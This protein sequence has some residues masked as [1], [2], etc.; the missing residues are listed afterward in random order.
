MRITN[1]HGLPETI[2][3]AV[4]KQRPPKPG[5]LHVSQ[6]I[7]PPLQVALQRTYF[8]DIEEDASDR[9]WILFGSL[10]HGVLADNA[11]PGIMVEETFQMYAGWIVTGTV[12]YYRDRVLADYKTTSVWSIIKGIKP[13]WINQINLYATLLE[14]N[15]WPV[16]RAE[17]VVILRD[18]SRSKAKQGGNYPQSNV[19]VLPMPVWDDETRLDYLLERVA[20]HRAAAAQHD[21]ANIIVCTPE[22][23]WQ[24]PTAYAV[25]K[26]GRKR[27]VKVFKGENAAVDAE[28]YCIRPPDR[29]Y[30][31]VQER[32]SIP[33][34]CQHYCNVNKWCPW[35]AENKPEEEA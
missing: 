9:I 22:E 10:L 6:L 4:S 8:D 3:R 29:I 2:V 20:L 18:W 33:R 27:A 25:M 14:A 32:P 11:G 31:F 17:I 34:R 24:D 12:D 26:K 21:P 23:R 13:E 30:L 16:E 35:W 5:V 7:A 28:E 15:G 19:I 1:V